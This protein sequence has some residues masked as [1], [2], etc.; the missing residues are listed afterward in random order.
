MAGRG[1]SVQES[2]TVYIDEIQQAAA[3]LYWDEDDQHD[4]LF[5][6]IPFWKDVSPAP[7]EEL[8]SMI[9]EDHPNQNAIDGH[10]IPRHRKG[11]TDVAQQHL[12]TPCGCR[13]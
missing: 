8:G 6:G 7:Y 11:K 4:E 9:A 10:Q 12:S 2:K 13:L 5:A 1:V 3:E